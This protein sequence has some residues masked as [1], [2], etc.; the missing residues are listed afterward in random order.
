MTSCTWRP[1][2]HFC[3]SIFTTQF[4]QYFKIVVIAYF[5]ELFKMC[6][7]ISYLMMT[8]NRYLLIGKDHS[9]LLVTLAKLEFKWVIRGSILVSAFL[10]IG[11]GWEFKVVEDVAVTNTYGSIYAQV[12]GYS[13]SDYPQ[14]NQDQLYLA[15]SIVYFVL[16]FGVF[17]VLNTTIEVNIVRR[18]HKELKEK[19][20]RLAQMDNVENFSP[21]NLH[22]FS[23]K[24]NV[25]SDNQK[26][27]K[28]E[29]DKKERRVVKMVILNSVFNFVLR[30][31][32]VLF[33]TE[34]QNIMSIFLPSDFIFQLYKLSEFPP[35]LLSFIVDIGYLTYILT[36]S[37]NFF[38]FYKFNSKFKG[39]VAFWSC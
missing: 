5:G 20:E 34:N 15:Y 36:F 3:S 25:Q 19:R 29:E 17:F 26:K 2:Y 6:A 13:F 23:P 39:A 32:D 11:H 35:G 31:P 7:N 22:S 30:A 4:V 27:R 28:E 38:I 10:N 1:S 24:V 14:A 8:L 37:S 18:M 12:N 9:P 33:L 21:L 16:N